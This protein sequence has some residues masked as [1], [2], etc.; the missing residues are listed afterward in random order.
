MMTM[1]VDRVTAVCGLGT[2]PLCCS[3]LLMGPSGWACAK[4]EGNERIYSI[5][6]SRRDDGSIK[7]MGDNC[8]GFGISQGAMAVATPQAESN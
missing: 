7:A 8:H 4:S 3:F 1:D 6:Q 2:G 5:L